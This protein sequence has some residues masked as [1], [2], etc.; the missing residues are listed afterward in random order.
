MS[1]LSYS[2]L[3]YELNQGRSDDQLKRIQSK[4]GIAA[5]RQLMNRVAKLN[6]A[7]ESGKSGAELDARR[8]VFKLSHDQLAQRIKEGAKWADIGKEAGVRSTYAQAVWASIQNRYPGIKY[9]H[10]KGRGRNGHSVTDEDKYTVYMF[11]TGEIS[12]AQAYERLTACGRTRGGAKQILNKHS[13]TDINNLTEVTASSRP[14][15]LSNTSIASTSSSVGTRYEPQQHQQPLMMTPPPSSYGSSRSSSVE[16]EP[17]TPVS[18]PISSLL[19]P[20]GAGVDEEPPKLRKTISQSV[21]M[22]YWQGP[23]SQP[24]PMLV[25]IQSRAYD[26]SYSYRLPPISL[27]RAQ[28]D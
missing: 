28:R 24:L 11:R 18:L 9:A 16:A 1:R 7:Q 15:A 8:T 21:P 17:T 6:T 20:S 14:R 19:Q 4:Y 22:G 3:E 2:Q 5:K 27:E 12:R 23:T 25:P 26:E 10:G 13:H